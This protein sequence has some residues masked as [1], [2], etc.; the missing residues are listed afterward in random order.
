MLSKRALHGLTEKA[1][2]QTDKANSDH[3]Q[4]NTGQPMP[5]WRAC[6]LLGAVHCAWEPCGQ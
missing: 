5:D 1:H 6:G 3:L 2:S 4:C